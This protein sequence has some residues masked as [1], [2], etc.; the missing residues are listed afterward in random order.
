MIYVNKKTDYRISE[1][2]DLDKIW[3]CL[4]NECYVYFDKEKLRELYEEFCEECYCAHFLMVDYGIIEEFIDWLWL[5]KS[6]RIKGEL[7]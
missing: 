1:E 3:D 5:V 4:H 2:Q 7:K 6:E